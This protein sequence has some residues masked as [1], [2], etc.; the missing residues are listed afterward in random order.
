MVTTL[1]VLTLTH[2]GC[3]ECHATYGL[4]ERAR[5][6]FQSVGTRWHCPYCDA[7]QSYRDNDL[8]REKKARERAEWD[9]KRQRE[10]AD[11]YAR[12]AVAAEHS[13]RTTKGHLTRIK[14]RVA[15]G[16]CPC[17]NRTFRDLGRHMKGQHPGYAEVSP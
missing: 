7:G 16:I 12:R 1:A 15:A 4:D 8:A 11:N 9:A 10:R 13:Q 3:S 17:C 2:M 6:R 5:A 14:R